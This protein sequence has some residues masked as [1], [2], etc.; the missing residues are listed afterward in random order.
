MEFITKMKKH[1]R[2]SLP[3]NIETVVTYQ[4]KTF[5]EKF[6]VKDKTEFFHQSSLVYY[7]KC[8]NQTCAEDNIGK[9]DRKI[10]ERIIEI[11]IEIIIEKFP[12][13]KS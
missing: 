10:Q 5:S 2:K 1:I 4:S 3:E 6:H 8:P 9:I 13:I 7:E 12:C 11:I